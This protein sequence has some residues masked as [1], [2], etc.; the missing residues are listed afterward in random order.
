MIYDLRTYTL[1]PRSVPAVERLF[2]D[3]M[4]TREKYSR[5]GAFFHT[6]VG[7]LNQIIHIWP[8]ADL[9]E[10]ERVR[11][12]SAADSSGMWPP[13]GLMQ[14]VVTMESELLTPAPFMVDWTGPQERGSLYELRTYDLVPGT[15]GDVMKA[16]A[17]KIEGRI[18]YSPLAGC[19][20][21]LGTGGPQNRLH[22][23][24]AYASFEERARVRRETTAAGVWPSDTG[25][26]YL[27]QENK[28]LT[29]AS[30][31]PLH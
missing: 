26:S 27:R 21:S 17:S 7:P 22:H 2:A 23:L 13:P 1:K 20:V 19:W 6:E 24:W 3:S 8:Y 5:L 9:A 18:A 25:E 15:R 11:A 4:P 10:L 28:L 31:S 14:Y 30:F 16:W 12:E 29:P